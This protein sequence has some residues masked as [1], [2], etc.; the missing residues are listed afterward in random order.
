MTG[1]ERDE[2]TGKYTGSYKDSDFLDAIRASNGMA[3][4]SEV[5]E[6]TG[7]SYSTAYD[8]LRDLEGDGEVESQEVGNSLL[9]KVTDE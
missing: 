2:Q 4:T 6:V 3:G 7:C 8:R 5:A 1:R 9:W